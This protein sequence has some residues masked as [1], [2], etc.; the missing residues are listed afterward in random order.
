MKSSMGAFTLIVEEET[1]GESYYLG[2]EQSTDWPG[3]ASGVTIGC[4]YDCGYVTAGEI[5]ADWGGRLD[6]VM[7]KTLQGIA[8]VHGS[9]AR[10][11]AHELHGRIEVPWD[12]ALG[13][14]RERD[15]PKWEAI[16]A[17][18]LPNC[19]RL[20]GNSFGA[21]VSLAFNRGASFSLPGPRYSEMRAIHALMAA[22]EFAD[23]PAQIRAMKR[24]WPSSKD[25]RDRR[26]HEAA[27]FEQGLRSGDKRAG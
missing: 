9:P 12:V 4:G 16:V 18:A 5:A 15:V 3:G 20:S 21:L 13:V 8:G 27:L 2:T 10:A 14:F 19:D 22:Q 26:D 6:P 25:L 1:G 23:I 11:L 17:T 7:I 24:L